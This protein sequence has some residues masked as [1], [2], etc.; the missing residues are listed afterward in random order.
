[1]VRTETPAALCAP[2]VPAVGVGKAQCSRITC[3]HLQGRLRTGRVAPHWC[4]TR[5]ASNFVLLNFVLRL[6]NPR[7]SLSLCARDAAEYRQFFLNINPT[8]Q[9]KTPRLPD[10]RTQRGGEN[11]GSERP[12]RP[13]A[14]RSAAAKILGRND[15][16]DRPTLPTESVSNR[17]GLTRP[18]DARSAAAKK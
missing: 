4:T 16:T 14:A 10:R 7:R 12:D 13:T 15:P 9:P 17:L 6:G 8:D 18:T 5:F 2:Q 11:F 3:R 1:M